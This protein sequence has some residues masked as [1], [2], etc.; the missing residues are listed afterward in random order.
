M[1]AEKSG[2]DRTANAFAILLRERG[3]KTDDDDD[4]IGLSAYIH[5]SKIMNQTIIES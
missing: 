5:R 2:K 1:A 3:S 4:D